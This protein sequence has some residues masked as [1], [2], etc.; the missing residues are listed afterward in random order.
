M[1]YTVL[2]IL[3]SSAAMCDA[4]AFDEGNRHFPHFGVRSAKKEPNKDVKEVKEEIRD[5]FE[6]AEKSIF[7]AMERCEKAVEHAI[8]DEVDCFFHET[9]HD[10]DDETKKAS[11]VSDKPSKPKRSPF[12]FSDDMVECLQDCL[13]GPYE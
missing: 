12:H 5:D 8:E 9:C 6:V 7:D 10:N 2:I 1:K 4:I 11:L 3:A 13:N